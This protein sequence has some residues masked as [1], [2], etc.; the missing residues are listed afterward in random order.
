M[1]NNRTEWV[2]IAEAARLLSV[3]ARTVRRWVSE[4]KIPAMRDGK[5]RLV[6]DSERLGEKEDKQPDNILLRE[7][8]IKLRAE[9]DS[10][11]AI[12]RTLTGE[13]DYLRQQVDRLEGLLESQNVII[14]TMQMTKQK[15]L[16]DPA[17]RRSWWKRFSGWIDP[18]AGTDEPASE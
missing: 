18:T 16:P 14:Q 7:E 13:R 4:G 10:H 15:T 6:D 1:D 2:P 3:N 8:N 11:S 12:I 17:K 9:A 5:R